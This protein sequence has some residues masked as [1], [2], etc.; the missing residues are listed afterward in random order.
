MTTASEHTQKALAELMEACG[1]GTVAEKLRACGHAFWAT[2]H[3][4][5]LDK[6]EMLNTMCLVSGIAVAVMLDA[7]TLLEEV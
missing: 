5:G 6:Q 1:T 3:D 2:S 7:A 4:E